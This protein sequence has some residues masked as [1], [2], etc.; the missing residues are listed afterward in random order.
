MTKKVILVFV[1]GIAT[2]ALAIAA[3]WILA[4]V[5]SRPLYGYY[6]IDAR[7]MGGHE[8]FLDLKMDLAYQ[9][10]PGHRDRKLVGRVIRD[11]SSATVVDPK[12]GKLWFR[13]DW[14]GIGH[15]LTFL[16]DGD[17]SSVIGLIRDHKDLHQVTSPFRIWLPRILS[18]DD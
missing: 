10:C 3:F 6:D 15:S 8:I 17:S 12:D 1:G 13:I 5:K 14:N 18:K 2:I 4:S 16:K 9:Y 7:C 11:S